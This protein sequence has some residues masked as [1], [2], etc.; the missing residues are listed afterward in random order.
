MLSRLPIFPSSDFVK[1]VKQA[2][3]LPFGSRS[4]SDA[5]WVFIFLLLRLCEHIMNTKLYEQTDNALKEHS[6][7][8]FI[9]ERQLR[10]IERLDQEIVVTKRNIEIGTV[11]EEAIPEPG[12]VRAEQSGCD[13]PLS[14]EEFRTWGGSFLRKFWHHFLQFFVNAAS[15]SF[16]INDE[17]G[18]NVLTLESV[19]VLMKRT[20][21]HLKTTNEIA[22]ESREVEFLKALPPSF[23]RQFSSLRQLVLQAPISPDYL[24]ECSLR[25]ASVFI[26][27]SSLA[28]LV[29]ISFIYSLSSSY[30]LS[31]LMVIY[32]VG[33]FCAIDIRGHPNVYRVF[34]FLSVSIL[35]LRSLSRCRIIEV[36]L[37]AAA[38]TG[39]T[40][41]SANS[42]LAWIGLEPDGH[43]A[44][45]ILLFHASLW[46]I[47]DRFENSPVFPPKFY[48]DKF[49]IV[50]DSFPER[51]CYGIVPDPVHTLALEAPRT[52]SFTQLMKSL[53]SRLGICH[54][55]HRT[56][57]LVLDFLS[58]IFILFAWSD[59]DSTWSADLLDE[60]ASGEFRITILSLFILLIHIG[61]AIAIEFQM[62]AQKYYRLFLLNLLS[63]ITI[64]VL[65]C[66]YLPTRM[67]QGPP[68]SLDLFI[69]I[70]L[71]VHVTISHKCHVGRIF[72][73]FR[74]P[75]FAK[76]WRQILFINYIMR[77]CPFIFETQTVLMWMVEPTRVSSDDFM[78]IRDITTRIGILI[79]EQMR[80][81]PD[82]PPRAR[83]RTFNGIAYLLVF[84]FILF[85]PLFV[86]SDS[87]SPLV[88]NRLETG[89][90]EIGFAEF[91]PFYQSEGRV[92]EMMEVEK[93]YLSSVNDDQLR[94]LAMQPLFLLSFP[95]TSTLV[96][97]FSSPAEDQ[98]R[99]RL[100]N[101]TST[102][103]LKVQF[104]F[105]LANPTTSSFTRDPVFQ[106]I[107]EVSSSVAVDYLTNGNS[108]SLSLNFGQRLPRILLISFESSPSSYAEFEAAFELAFVDVGTFMIKLH[109][110]GGR[111]ATEALSEADG[112]PSMQR[113]RKSGKRG[114]VSGGV[115]GLVPE[116]G[117]C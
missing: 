97:Q 74:Y 23:G 52:A 10:I 31:V 44:I 5:K 79:A 33:I 89:S 59:W 37:Q 17:P 102:I 53:C 85:F 51:Y 88:H 6:G 110:A 18:L 71:V 72:A 40:G 22:L 103:K 80:T 67:P 106:H 7:F 84:I 61:L 19:S 114:A 101:E 28:V 16:Y 90:L 115:S 50:L 112:N 2:F 92:S 20:L 75:N 82:Q 8:R 108:T 62:M 93:G 107:S 66:L 54:T 43:I 12:F 65:C 95:M 64:M 77:T 81:P 41:A 21:T 91:P 11:S 117:T 73:S 70:R 99:E 26:R 30:I 39:M 48:Y 1:I 58:A 68:G 76:N 42:N 3:D 87:Q 111:C 100:R 49:V 4:I 56:V 29:L 45:E 13:L 105:H 69:F 98:L 63:M 27:K 109:R 57:I 36:R 113:C 38:K 25:Y 86:M 9:R 35:G 83:R 116:E 60:D 15:S 94:R 14:I 46:Y 34:L 55:T 104:R 24:T 96:S 47:V 32:V 78:L